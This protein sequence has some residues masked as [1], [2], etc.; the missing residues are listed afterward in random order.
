MPEASS[1]I[2]LQD[3]RADEV[4]VGMPGRNMD[5]LELG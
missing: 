5:R 3:M 4:E 2:G 1:G